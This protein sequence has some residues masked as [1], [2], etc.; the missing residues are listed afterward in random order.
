MTARGEHEP[1]GFC[2]RWWFFGCSSPLPLVAHWARGA[3]ETRLGRTACVLA[4]QQAAVVACTV[5]S[6]EQIARAAQPCFESAHLAYEQCWHNLFLT[7]FQPF[8]MCWV[9]SLGQEGTGE[10]TKLIGRR[11]VI[12]LLPPLRNVNLI[13]GL[14]SE[15][16]R[17]A[18][19]M[20]RLYTFANK[21]SLV[22]TALDFKGESA[23]DQ[24]LFKIRGGAP[25]NQPLQSHTPPCY[26]GT[27]GAAPGRADPALL[28]SP[29]LAAELCC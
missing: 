10:S 23:S 17:I 4:A 27:R 20:A 7:F 6:P 12:Y 21:T 14:Q 24:M 1:G 18:K 11:N 29:P 22:S 9:K 2:M 25:Q 19:I 28:V 13:L 15:Q 8:G 3:P 5:F 16:G 26:G